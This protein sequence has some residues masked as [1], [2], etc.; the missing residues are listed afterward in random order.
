VGGRLGGYGI[1][2]LRRLWW[3]W[4]DGLDDGEVA[5]QEL[6]SALDVN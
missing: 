6:W 5:L 2:W 3:W 4:I 1:G